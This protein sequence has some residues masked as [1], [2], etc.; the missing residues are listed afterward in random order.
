[1]AQALLTDELWKRLEPLI[2]KPRRR[3]RHVQYAGRKPADARR[4]VNGILF[5]LRTGVPWRALPATTDFPSGH[6]CRR[7]LRRWHKAGIWQRLFETLLAELQKAHQIDWYRALVDSS[8]V[9]APRGGAKTGPN[10][11]DRSK[12]GSKHHLLTD[13]QGIPLAIILTK[14][15]R[16]DVTQLLPL[17]DKIPPVR[18]KRGAPRFRPE[19]VQG[20]R[21]YDSEPHRKALKKRG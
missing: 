10:P 16:H 7:R 2:P 17:L 6:T 11:T 19:R 15:N 12:R 18:G 1:M 3:N 5:V 9:R 8:S 14:A 21:A 13:A 20:D 4:V